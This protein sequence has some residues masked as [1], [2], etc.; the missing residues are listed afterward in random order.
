MRSLGGGE[1]TAAIN[2]ANVMA[3]RSQKATLQ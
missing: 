3:V 2:I 1:V